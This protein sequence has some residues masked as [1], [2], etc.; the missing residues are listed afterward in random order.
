MA[1]RRTK[2]RTH[3]RASNA[4]ANGKNGVKTMSRSPK[5][6]VIRIGAGELGSSVSQLVK[7][8]RLMM[9]PDTA[10]RLKVTTYP[11]RVVS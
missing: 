4:T 7:D 3:I 11:F 9:E 6:M 5:S 1:K 2:T 10:S 8:V